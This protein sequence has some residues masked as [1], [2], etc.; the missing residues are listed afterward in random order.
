[1]NAGE[2]VIGLNKS[3]TI[4]VIEACNVSIRASVAVAYKLEQTALY[5][6]FST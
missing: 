1:M 6:V 4:T 5:E 2:T 3:S